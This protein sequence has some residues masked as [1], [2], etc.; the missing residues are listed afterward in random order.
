MKTSTATEVRFV[1]ATE[2][3]LMLDSFALVET[4]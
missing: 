2:V 4:L 3:E 1:I